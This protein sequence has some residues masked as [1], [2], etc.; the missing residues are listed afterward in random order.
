MDL[1]SLES[2]AIIQDNKNQGLSQDWG[3]LGVKVRLIYESQTLWI[4]EAMVESEI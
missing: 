1:A 4:G 2:S 3:V